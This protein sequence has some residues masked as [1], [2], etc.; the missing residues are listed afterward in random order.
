MTEKIAVMFCGQGSRDSAAVEEF[1]VLALN[2]KKYLPEY[3]V[4]SGFLEFATPA[5]SDGLDKLLR[6]GAEKIVCVPGML[7]AAGN[8]KDD[9]PSEIKTYAHAHDGLDVL[10]G[11]ALAIDT[12]LLAAA[13][14]RIEQAEKKAGDHILREDTLLMVVGHGSN[15]P[16]ANANASKVARMLWEGMGFGWAEVSYS[17][18]AHPLVDEGMKKAIKLGYKRI[19]VFPYVLF[20]GALLRRLYVWADECAAAN[21]DVEIVK[22]SYLN[23]HEQLLDCFVDRVREALRGS[24]NMNCQHCEYREQTI[25]DGHD[26]GHHHHGDKPEGE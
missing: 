4:E 21:P 12:K 20:T 15:D 24:G 25:G 26:H 19:I 11:R 17:D 18:G 8:G 5:I 10:L 13:C 3:D 9:L 22:A 1:N 16:D 7:F 6:R 14:D 2:V 23:D